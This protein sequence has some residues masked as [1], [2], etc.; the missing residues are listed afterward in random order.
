MELIKKKTKLNPRRYFR[1][2]AVANGFMTSM[3]YPQM[4]QGL[5]LQ[6][7]D[8]GSVHDQAHTNPSNRSSASTISHFYH[9]IS[10]QPTVN[11]DATPSHNQFNH[12][13]NLSIRSLSNTIEII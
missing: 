12:N 10:K 7:H 2:F 5:Q 3:S 11:T 13:D 1:H 9:E 4:V 6:S 8:I